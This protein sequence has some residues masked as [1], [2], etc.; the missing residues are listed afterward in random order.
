MQLRHLIVLF[1]QH[2]EYRLDQFDT[3]QQPRVIT[4]INHMHRCITS[5]EIRRRAL[6]DELMIEAAFECLQIKRMKNTI[7]KNSLKSTYDSDYD[8]TAYDL[9]EIVDTEHNFEVIRFSIRHKSTNKIHYRFIQ[10]KFIWDKLTV[11]PE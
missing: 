6:P 9:D 11:S 4:A 2:K 8:C 1:A 3:F 5:T 10:T 7:L